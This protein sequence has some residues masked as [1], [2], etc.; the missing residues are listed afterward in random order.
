LGVNLKEE[1]MFAIMQS[2]SKQYRVSQGERLLIEKIDAAVGQDIEFTDVLLVST[3]EKVL[4][5]RPRVEKAVVIGTAEP[6]ERADKIYPLKKK[7]RKNY[8]R[9][10]GHRQTMSV[11]RIKE[12]RTS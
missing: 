4:V 7:R 5:G 6:E 12:I 9:R 3:G 2:G 8:R 10:I 1:M 11:V